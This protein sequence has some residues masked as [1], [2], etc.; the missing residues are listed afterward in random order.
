MSQYSWDLPEPPAPPAVLTVS[1]LVLRA[2]NA[3]EAEF[4]TVAV[5][6]EVSSS[7]RASSGHLYWTLKDFSSAVECVMY[8][9]D[10]Q[11]LRFEIED[12]AHVVVV[13]RPTIYRVRGRFQLAVTEVLPQGRGALYLKLEALREKLALEGLFDA[14]RKRP[15]PF[16][17][18][19]VGVV[20]SAEGAALRDICTVIGRRAPSTR[21]LLKAVP[22]QGKDAAPEIARA[23]RWFGSHGVAEVLI[24]GRGGGSLEDLWAFNEEIVV[25]AIA[26]SPVPVV[27]AVG[28]E[29]DT[30]LADLAADLRAP[31]PSAA[32]E[33]VVPETPA[34]A[35]AV[36]QCFRRLSR[37]MER[38]RLARIESALA[39]IRRYGFRRVRDRAR[40]AR[41]RWGEAADRLAPAMAGRMDG[42]RARLSGA[43]EGL[44][45]P[46]AG[47]LAVAARRSE[48]A[49]ALSRET[50]RR[51][52]RVRTR[53]A[54]LAERLAA[55]SPF[56]IL[57]RGYAIV[58]GPD[59]RVARDAARLAAG[60]AL[61]IQL[62]RGEV[63]ATVSTT[64]PDKT[65][66][67]AEERSR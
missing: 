46:L 8:R 26:A 20:T 24:V 59:G 32:A 15:L 12:G 50:A 9:T 33:H 6:G 7:K 63:G 14:N 16:W 44:A 18:L 25:R 43:A 34:I 23:I 45:D 29:S 22:V 3:L 30:T 67:A 39:P 27:S 5:E 38:Q 49:R 13:A 57:E 53:H 51:H 4:G 65:P 41:Q 58:A 35:R 62:A 54:H 31:T 56:A 60:D 2:S 17:P 19:A 36:V 61:V 28:H 64:N 66:E 48:R 1:A 47:R 52:E 37:A 40:E 21:I 10:N 42:G 55:V 11:R